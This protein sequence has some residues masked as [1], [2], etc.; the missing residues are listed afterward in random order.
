MTDRLEADQTACVSVATDIEECQRMFAEFADTTAERAPL[1]ARLSAAI[2]A[3]AELAAQLT[4]APWAERNPALLLASVQHLLLGEPDQEL[5][6]YYPNLTPHPAAGDP[7]PAFG[8]F[9]RRHR[10]QVSELVATRVVQTNEVGRCALLVPALAL[11]AAEMGRLAQVDIGCSAGLNLA[12]PAY[13][14]RYQPGGDL[15]IASPVVMACHTRGPVPVPR[16]M[17]DV[18]VAI[19]L[20]RRPI[21]VRDPEQGRWLE[22]CVWP[23]QVDRF[24]RLSAAIAL[25]RATPPELRAGDAVTALPGLVDEAARSGHPVV[26]TSWVLNYLPEESRRAWWQRLTRIGR[27]QDLSWLYAEQPA[28]I[29]GS[30]PVPTAPRA[31]AATALVLVTW[32]G[33]RQHFRHLADCHPHGYWLQWVDAEPR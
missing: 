25:A 3:D 16:R 6:T 9:C 33:G 30:L 11:L 27:G 8:R 15:G 5:A 28:L 26:T 22:A 21:D 10:D 20:D 17:P 31:R 1:Y 29:A 19:G 23:D 7:V 32:R 4:A 18:G 2:A 12:W 14:Y 13:G 24:R